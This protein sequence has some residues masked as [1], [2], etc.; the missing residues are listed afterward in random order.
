MGVLGDDG[1]PTEATLDRIRRWEVKT[2]GDARKAMDYAGAAWSYP[3]RWRCQ[4]RWRGRGSPRPVCRYTFSTGG[5][6]GN[7]EIVAAI[8]A[9]AMLQMLGAWSWR[10]GGH[11]EYR[12][13]VDAR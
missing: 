13:P 5:W 7:E 1:Y 3:D 10:R 12:F 4:P 8:E 11:Y 2:F 6:S 9:N